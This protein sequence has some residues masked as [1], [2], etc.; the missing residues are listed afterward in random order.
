M[1]YAFLACIITAAMAWTGCSQAGDEGMCAG[2]VPIL[3]A[4]PPNAAVGV[5]TDAQPTLVFFNGTG[6][7]L[8][9]SIVYDAVPKVEVAG[10]AVPGQLAYSIDGS[11]PRITFTPDAPLLPNTVYTIRYGADFSSTFTTGTA[12]VSPPPEPTSVGQVSARYWGGGTTQLIHVDAPKGVTA[13]LIHLI[14]SDGAGNAA[15]DRHASERGL[16]IATEAGHTDTAGGLGLEELEEVCY[17]ART[18][19]EAGVLSAPS[20]PSCVAP[21]DMDS[22][23]VSLSGPRPADGVYAVLFAAACSALCRRRSRYATMR[24]LAS[25]P[26]VVM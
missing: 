12:T 13:P 26:A 20:A 6:C 4:S 22:C 14:P 3:G 1:K 25:G 15:K 2:D 21:T 17:V 11:S 24:R 23:A 10:V 7:D 9:E 5:A 19:N 18:E 8:P 16:L